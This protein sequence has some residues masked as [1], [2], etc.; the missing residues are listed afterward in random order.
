[1]L[2]YKQKLP[3]LPTEHGE[4]EEKQIEDNRGSNPQAA[5]E[6]IPEKK[7]ATTMVF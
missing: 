7:A 6:G 3:S 4:E 5:F 1:M 2:D